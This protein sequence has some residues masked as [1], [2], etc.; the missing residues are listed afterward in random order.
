VAIGVALATV[1]APLV[2]WLWADMN[3]AL[4]VGVSVLLASATATAVGVLLP[5]I[6][7]QLRIDSAVGSGPLAT[8]IQDLLSIWI[9][10]TVAALLI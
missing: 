5:W 7:D 3:L 10:L 8:V 2:W 1:T 4:S 9:Y 6:F